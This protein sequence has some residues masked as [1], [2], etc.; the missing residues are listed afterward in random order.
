MRKWVSGCSR[1]DWPAAGVCGFLRKAG[2][3]G[4]F[5][6]DFATRRN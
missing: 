2:N 3:V 6:G 4:Y 5:I 1:P